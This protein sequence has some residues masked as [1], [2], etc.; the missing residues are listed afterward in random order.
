MSIKLHCAGRRSDSYLLSGISLLERLFCL[1]IKNAKHYF[2]REFSQSGAMP[3][4]YFAQGLHL[5]IG[6]K[7]GNRTRNKLKTVFGISI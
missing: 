2:D 3:I 6:R 4:N 1:Q 7:Q 5:K